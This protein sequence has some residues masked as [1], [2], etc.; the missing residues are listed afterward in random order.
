MIGYLMTGGTTMTNQSVHEAALDQLYRY[1]LSQGLAAGDALPPL[2]DLAGRFGVSVASLREAVRT[3][4]ASGVVDIR[5]GVG[6]FLQAY[7]YGPILQ[8]LSF[9]ALFA[10]DMA[11][12]LLQTRQALEIG[13]V[14]P[15][16]DRL[17]IEDLD[18]LAG[19]TM[20]MQTSESALA[21]EYGFHRRLYAALDNPL[22]AGLLRLCWLSAAQLTEDGIPNRVWP[23]YAVH[24]ELLEALRNRDRLAAQASLSRYFDLLAREQK[25]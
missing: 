15:A 2:A 1:I 9:S 24:L 14:A 25:P 19:Y 21:A 13:A 11:R 16:L 23:H 6:T 10:P 8:N 18:A 12:H 22:L 4:E 5:H 7:D 17:T 20:E 3:L